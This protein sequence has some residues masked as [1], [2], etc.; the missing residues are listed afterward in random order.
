[1][2]SRRAFATGC[3]GLA[4]SLSAPSIVRATPSGVVGANRLWIIR[5]YD[6]DRLDAPIRLKTEEGTRRAWQLWSHFWRDVKDHDKGV[7]I[8]MRLLS[9]M[10]GVQ[11]EMSRRRGEEV[12]LILTSGYRTPE[13]NA[14]IEG[15]APNSQHCE[16]CAADF[17]GR[18]FTPRETADIIEAHPVWGSGGL[19]RY[20]NFTHLDTARQRRWGRN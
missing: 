11:V 20:S 18:G 8:D 19:G 1:M 5:A 16:G 9:R 7:W 14:T 13:R 17:T 15:A 6:G 4:T 12:P 3:L 10:S 2:L